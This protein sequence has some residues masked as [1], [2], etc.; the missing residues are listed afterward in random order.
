MDGLATRC[1]IAASFHSTPRPTAGE[2]FVP[3][4]NE[5]TIAIG[6]LCFPYLSFLSGATRGTRVISRN[7]EGGASAK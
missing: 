1:R 6:Q 5:E 7:E 3:S 4:L 2:A